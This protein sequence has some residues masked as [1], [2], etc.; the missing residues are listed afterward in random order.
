MRSSARSPSPPREG[1]VPLFLERVGDDHP[2]ACTGRRLLDRGLARPAFRASHGVRGLVLDPHA[3]RPLSLADR[4]AGLRG[5]LLAVDC[6]WNR[7]G[8]TGRFPGEAGEARRSRTARRLPWLLAANPQHFG[9]L[10]EL[11]T[12]EALAA[13]LYL[14]GEEARARALLDGFPGGRSFFALNA[15]SLAAYRAAP[16]ADGILAAELR[17][18]GSPTAPRSRAPRSPDAPR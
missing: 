16:D 7:L 5:G 17:L 18:A 6:S 2:K 13:G 8:A 14:L 12:A 11:N 1:E 4:P 3:E 9:R 15:T 10:A